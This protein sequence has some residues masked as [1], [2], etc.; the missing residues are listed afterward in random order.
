[1][2]QTPKGRLVQGLYKPIHGTC[3]MYFSL[4]VFLGETVPFWRGSR[5]TTGSLNSPDVE[6]LATA[7][8][9]PLVPWI[10]VGGFV[11]RCLSDPNP[12]GFLRHLFLFKYV[13]YIYICIY[14][15]I[16]VY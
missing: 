1:M 10:W 16:Y 13:V 15:Y 5:L 7:T 3:S 11:G 14:I 8:M 4:G 12:P 2:A 9:A 6:R